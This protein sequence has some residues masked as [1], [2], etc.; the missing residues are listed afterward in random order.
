MLPFQQS[1]T[2]FLKKMGAV[3]LHCACQIQVFGLGRSH[4]QRA[5]DCFSL[6]RP[7]VLEDTSTALYMLSALLCWAF[8]RGH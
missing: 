6:K 2:C 7:S 4:V 8:S 1:K 5:V 3:T